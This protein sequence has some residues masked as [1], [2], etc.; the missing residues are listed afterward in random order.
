M[1]FPNTGLVGYWKLDESSGNAVDAL[2]VNTLTNTGTA[3]YSAGKINNGVD[4][5]ATTMYMGKANPTGLPSGT[6]AFSMGGWVK[7]TNFSTARYFF[8][9]GNTSNNGRVAIRCDS[10]TS[11]VIDDNGVGTAFP[12]VSAMSTGT[13]YHI[14]YTYPGSGNIYTAYLNGTSIGTANNTRSPN[15]GT[16]VLGLGSANNTSS[17]ENLVG[18]MDEWGIWSRELSSGEA[19]DLYNSGAGVSYIVNFPITADTGAFTLTGVSNNLL[20]GR[21]LVASAGSF[22]LTGIDVALNIGKGVLAGI[23]SFVLTGIDV[24]LRFSGWTQITK[25]TTTWTDQ[26]KNTTTWTQIDKH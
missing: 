23:G 25:N 18:S 3:T 6:T 10:S 22:V 16:T 13:W 8:G 20:F 2:G 4:F 15:I 19:S 17:A 26:T 1:A 21:N 11:W 24:A 5:S 14:L 12:A 9:F 7:F